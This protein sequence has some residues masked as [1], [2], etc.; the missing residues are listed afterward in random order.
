MTDLRADIVTAVGEIDVRLRDSWDALAVACARPLS[1]PGWLLAWWNTMAS[2]G[3]AARVVTV[4][5]GDELVG[6][7][8]FHVVRK[9]GVAQYLPFGTGMANR[10]GPLAVPGR[11]REVAAAIGMALQAAD[12]H[13]GVVHL[14]QIDVDSPWPAALAG[15][16]P[17]RRPFT[18]NR[19]VAPAPV[20]H[21][22]GDFEEWLAG[23]STN[24]RQRLRRD[25]RRLEGRGARTHAIT[26][27]AEFDR[28]MRAFGELHGARWGGQ[29][30][31]N[32][33]A[34]RALMLSAGREMLA[35]G[36]FRVYA[37]ET[38][39]QVVTVQ[40]FVAAGGEVAYWNGGWHPDWA[41][42]SPA[43]QGIVAGIKDGFERGDRRVDFGQGDHPYKQRLA[44]G[45]APVAW[46]SLY[47]HGRG[48][49]RARIVRL[50]PQVRDAASRAVE[51][52]PPH[53]RRQIDR[54]R[55]RV[56]G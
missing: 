8:P 40:L 12:P 24:F 25:G 17:G 29:S 49:L 35:G 5:D 33:D 45:D 6:I 36:R 34:G 28:I 39:D 31:L 20:L 22:R 41:Q 38:D 15:T 50:G 10:N 43:I 37:I 56:S 19:H 7:A 52:L 11:E 47:P 3:A 46:P 4:R 16:W 53:A 23:K 18:E 27:E 9:H 55:D 13:P 1:A 32:A 30:A 26:S 2:P 14:D 42:F 44:D 51:H 21:L 48:H 54:L